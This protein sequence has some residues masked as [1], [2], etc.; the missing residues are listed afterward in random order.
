MSESHREYKIKIDLIRIFAIVSVV[1]IHVISSFLG[2]SPFFESPTYWVANIIDAVSRVGVPLLVMISGYLNLGGNIDE[3][4]IEFIGKRA[5]RILWPLIVWCFIYFLWSKYYMH[6][7]MNITNLYD[8][9]IVFFRSYYHMY[10]MYAILGLTL[11]TPILKKL[12]ITASNFRIVLMIYSVF[13]IAF[14]VTTIKGFF[15]P[16]IH[17]FET[18]FT[19]FIPYISYYLAGY[20]YGKFL[21]SIKSS[22]SIFWIYIFT[23]LTT[24]LLNYGYMRYIGWGQEYSSNPSTYFYFFEYFSPTVVVMTL[25]IYLL[26][27]NNS[28]VVSIGKYV[29]LNWIKHLSGASFGVY[30]IHPMIINILNNYAIFDLARITSPVMAYMILKVLVVVIVSFG[31]VLSLRWI[32]IF[33]YFDGSKK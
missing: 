22:K 32:G 7:Q 10:F 5:K 6:F 9:I 15:I 26:T 25:T 1:T 4:A 12:I 18:T 13:I 30:L 14:I 31:V 8:F 21:T 3:N 33:Q 23:L 2:Y 17:T 19:Y 16:T 11:I 24:I 20:Y 28:L 27:I 29:P